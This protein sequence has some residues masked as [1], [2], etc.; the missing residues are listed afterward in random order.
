MAID[1][2]VFVI[3]FVML[4]LGLRNWDHVYHIIIIIIGQLLDYSNT[5]FYGEVFRYGF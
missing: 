4:A 5:N 3:M 2:F 1:V